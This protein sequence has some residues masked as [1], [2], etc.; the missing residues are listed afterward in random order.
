MSWNNEEIIEIWSGYRIINNCTWLWHFKLAI[1]W[2]NEFSLHSLVYHHK[3]DLGILHFSSLFNSLFYLWNFSIKH[4]GWSAYIPFEI[5]P[6]SH[7]FH[8]S[9]VTFKG[10]CSGEFGHYET[11]SF[12]RLERGCEA[13]KS[14]IDV[15]NT[16]YGHKR[17][18]SSSAPRRHRHCG[19]LHSLWVETKFRINVDLV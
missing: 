13:T 5:I 11:V 1:S 7:W 16:K 4:S 3:Y 17:D 2:R 10:V 18:T 6:S 8:C 12:R 15:W 14:G 19:V 9:F